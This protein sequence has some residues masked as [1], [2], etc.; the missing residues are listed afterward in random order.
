M[1]DYLETKFL[2]YLTNKHFFMSIRVSVENNKLM[3]F[4]KYNPKAT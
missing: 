2:I 3:H 1:K 4:G